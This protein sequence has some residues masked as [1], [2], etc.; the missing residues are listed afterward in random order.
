LRL[1]PLVIDEYQARR[2]IE[3]CDSVTVDKNGNFFGDRILCAG[4]VVRGKIR[5]DIVSR[6]P[7]VV[8]PAAQ[9][10]GNITAPSIAVGEG[11]CLEGDCR[12]GSILAIHPSS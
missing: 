12:I 1:Q 3:T 6:G 4:L 8:G 5:A 7:V 2:T 10:R 11:A 9:I